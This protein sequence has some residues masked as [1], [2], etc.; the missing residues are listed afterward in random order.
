M[1]KTTI[2]LLAVA[3]L[4][5]AATACAEST[6]PSAT[7]PPISHESYEMAKTAAQAQYQIDDKSCSALSGNA[8]DICDAQAK[9]KEN[10]SKADAE[11]A[12][13]TSPKSREAARLAR[14]D[15]NYAVAMETCDDLSG[16]GKDVC[17]KEAKA[18]LV[19][20][21]ADAN[22]ARVTS[23]T[24]NEA[25]D[26]QSEARAEANADKTTADYKVAIEKC[27]VLAGQVKDDCVNSAKA[28]FGKS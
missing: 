6:M 18:A 23:D 11:A 24:R 19:K 25:A 20:G 12:F 8:K 4:S 14:A 22:V 17:V 3:G 28:H 27:D 13:D 1:N 16:N 7:A 26:K 10:V 15:A 5:F 21:K 9:G 2:A